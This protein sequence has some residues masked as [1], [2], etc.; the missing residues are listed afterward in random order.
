MKL[1]RFMFL[2]V[3][4]AFASV[5]SGKVLT[6]VSS[7]DGMLTLTTGITQQG[8]PYYQLQR[9]KRLLIQASLLGL[10]LKDGA[11]DR[12]FR[13]LGFTRGA[14]KP[15]CVIIIMS[16]PCSLSSAPGK[17]VCSPLS[18]VFSTMASVFAMFFRVNRSLLT[19]LS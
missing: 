16:S 4:L 8:Q 15:A 5:V 13:L 6:K 17:V 12:D 9:G 7:P 1:V 11:L 10:Q 14:R 18:S 2:V 19:S 3:A